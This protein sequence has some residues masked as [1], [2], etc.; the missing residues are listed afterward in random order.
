MSHTLFCNLDPAW[1]F[2]HWAHHHALDAF[3]RPD[4]A[5][6]QI[7]EPGAASPDPWGDWPRRIAPRHLSAELAE[8]HELHRR[9]AHRWLFNLPALAE[10]PLRQAVQELGAAL[11]AARTRHRCIVTLPAQGDYGAA[12][13]ELATATWIDHLVLLPES[14]EPERRGHALRLLGALCADPELGAALDGVRRDRVVAL[15]LLATRADAPIT[16]T[17]VQHWP[18]LA[19]GLLDLGVRARGPGLD[20]GLAAWKDAVATAARDVDTLRNATGTPDDRAATDRDDPLES[21][22]CPWFFDRELP[23]RIERGVADFY[24]RL[25]DELERRFTQLNTAHQQWRQREI[26]REPAFLARLQAHTANSIGLSETARGTLAEQQVQI[27][28]TRQ[29]LVAEEEALLAGLRGELTPETRRGADLFG[30]ANR[31][32]RRP[33]F[34]EDAAVRQAERTTRTAALD[35]ASRRGFEFGLAW[36][37]ALA[38]LPILALRAPAWFAQGW[39]PYFADAGSW[40]PDAGWLLLFAGPYLGFGLHQIRRR[41]RVLRRALGVLNSRLDR[42]RQRH[43]LALDQTFRYQH[44]IVAMRRLVLL[45]E[46]IERVR[47]E[48]QAALLDL[49][50]LETALAGQCAYYADRP[51][52]PDPALPADPTADPARPALLDALRDRPPRDWLRRVLRDWPTDPPETIAVRDADFARTGTLLTTYLRR[53]ACIALTRLPAN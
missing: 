5:F 2:V 48:L 17:V 9:D 7:E 21:L 3:A 52:A 47:D 37:L 25:D 1:D 45:E 29:Q 18:R 22:R 46:Q 39:L 26:E 16:D 40:G 4:V 33:P 50:R 34:E 42:A 38:L 36:V 24:R 19:R 44:L 23:A 14:A 28:R 27:D 13:P 15:E 41:R 31:D 51:G 12:L 35:L 49:S 53:C 10:A 8:L 6:W 43:H 32:Y 20:R 11:P 30:G